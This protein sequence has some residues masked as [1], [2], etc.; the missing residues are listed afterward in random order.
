[1]PSQKCVADT[2]AACDGLL[3]LCNKALALPAIGTHIGGGRH[4]TMPTTWNGVGP[5]PPG[6]TRSASRIWY[7]QN[8]TCYLPLSDALVTRLQADPAQARL[9]GPEQTAL[10]SAIASRTTI[11]PATQGAVLRKI[12]LAGQGD[13]I[14]DGLGSGTLVSRLVG[15]DNAFFESTASAGRRASQVLSFDVDN[16]MAPLR[17]DGAV[18]G[19]LL[20]GS[21]DGAYGDADKPGTYCTVEETLAYVEAIVTAERALGIVTVTGTVLNRQVGT[22]GNNPDF[23]GWAAAFAAAIMSEGDGGRYGDYVE[24]SRAEIIAAGGYSLYSDNTHL[25]P[26][27]MDVLAFV[28]QRGIN[29]ALAAR[30]SYV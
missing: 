13:S 11:D 18:I 25:N 3:S 24:D 23:N 15:P 9:T 29:R 14:T 17:V 8:A 2:E 6:W 26:A 1:M 20:V 16:K 10:A 5:T 4:A 27:G 30:S 21:N 7:K 19:W 12:Y 28:A 22:W